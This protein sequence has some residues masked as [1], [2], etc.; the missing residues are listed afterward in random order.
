MPKITSDGELVLV[1]G[2]TGQVSVFEWA[3]GLQH[4]ANNCCS[5]SVLLKLTITGDN[6][7]LLIV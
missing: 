6:R 4:W 3:A 1:C 2:T 5:P 7:R